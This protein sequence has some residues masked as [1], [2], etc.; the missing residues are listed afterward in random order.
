MI[1]NSDIKIILWTYLDDKSAINL[2]KINKTTYNLSY[3]LYPCK[4]Y[5]SVGDI[6]QIKTIIDSKG[7]NHSM[8]KIKNLIV[9]DFNMSTNCLTLS[10]FKCFDIRSLI[11]KS[12]LPQSNLLY[13]TYPITIPFNLT[14]LE[15]DTVKLN[16]IND[17]TF[18]FPSTLTS[19]IFSCLNI[20]I[21][22]FFFSLQNLKELHL[23]W[24]NQII[25]LNYLPNYLT[26][27]H[28]GG[29]FDQKLEKGVLPNSLLYLNF[30]HNYNQELEIGILP[31][32]LQILV[33][34]SNFKQILKEN[35]LPLSLQSL[36]F[37]GPYFHSL[38]KT[39][40]SKNIFNVFINSVY[41]HESANIFNEIVN[42]NDF[43]IVVKII[44]DKSLTYYSQTGFF[45]NKN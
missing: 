29:I 31:N 1:F 28:L 45:I 14:K 22:N 40:F 41:V 17:N 24:F 36:L 6:L 7:Y 27:L 13:F 34:G 18:I 43:K 12:S 39:L 11:W 35:V 44:R 2:M 42:D 21:K 23:N 3:P 33:F 20:N 26:K 30:G 32:N 19:L 25:P 10:L 4:K 9:N 8:P 16:K 37:E 5:F 38:R 15:I